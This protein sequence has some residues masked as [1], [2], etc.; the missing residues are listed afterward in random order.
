M[1]HRRY[2]FSFS[3]YSQ[4]LFA[5]SNTALSRNILLYARP[6]RVHRTSARPSTTHATRQLKDRYEPKTQKPDPQMT[7]KKY[8]KQELTRERIPFRWST[9]ALIAS[10]LASSTPI[11]EGRDDE[12]PSPPRGVEPSEGPRVKVVVPATLAILG[13]DLGGW[14]SSTR[15]VG[16]ETSLESTTED[17]SCLTDGSVEG[18]DAE[19][20]SSLSITGLLREMPSGTTSWGRVMP[21]EVVVERE[22]SPSLPE[23][24]PSGR[25]EATPSVEEA[26][27]PKSPEMWEHLGASGAFSNN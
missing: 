15:L 14:L 12:V 3:T 13:S 4:A 18:E 8:G 6:P 23:T 2:L 26:S 22:L 11:L 17:V 16:R 9:I 7:R 25:Q 27:C 5:Q 24:I 1:I 21:K 20:P 19:G 10:A